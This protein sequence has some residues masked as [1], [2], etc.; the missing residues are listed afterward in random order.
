MLTVKTKLARLKRLKLKF[1]GGMGM[2]QPQ[3]LVS[4]SE[5]VKEHP[6]LAEKDPAMG[7]SWD[8][9]QEMIFSYITFLTLF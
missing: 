4:W 2:E 6:E 8:M 7:M 3:L 5:I 9:S 1:K